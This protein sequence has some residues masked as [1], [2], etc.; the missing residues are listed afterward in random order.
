MLKQTLL[1]LAASL[2]LSPA[3][4]DDAVP[5]GKV[6]FFGIYLMNNAGDLDD[7]D[8]R[9]RIAMV[10]DQIAAELSE[11]GFT[12]VDISPVAEQL[13]SIKNI[14]SCNGCDMKLAQ[15]LGAD[16]S[17]T[18]E[19]QK[20]S[21]LILSM[22]FFLRDVEAR[23]NLRHGAVDIRGNT[24]ESWTRGYRYLLKNIIFRGES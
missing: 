7:S 14:A 2:I 15:E 13:K 10:E 17:A 11:R 6:A 20:T 16:Y 9:A 18:G 24:D 23:T 22:N 21:E 4:A 12:L 8:E 5:R 3:H 19:L 1:A